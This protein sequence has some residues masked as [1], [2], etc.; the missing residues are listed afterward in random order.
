MKEIIVNV[1]N[2]NENSIKTIEGDNLS[3]VYKIYICKNKRRIDLT[4]KIAI[5]AYVNEYGNKKSNI[6]ALNITNASQ[7]EI[8][9]PITNVISNE[10][11]VYACQIAIYGE[12]N[13]LEQTAPFS[14]IVENNIFSKISNSAINSSDFHIL[15]EAIKTTNSYAKKLKE[16]TENIEL[17]YA[18]KLNEKL[19]KD[20]VLSMANMGQDVK[21]AMT[22][23]SVAVVGGNS[24]SI[25]NMDTL[26]KNIVGEYIDNKNSYEKFN[27]QKYTHGVGNSSEANCQYF[28]REVSSGEKIKFSSYVKSGIDVYVFT[29]EAQR[30]IS[31]KTADIDGEYND[32][33]LVP[34]GAKRVY[35]N[36]DWSKKNFEV[37]KLSTVKDINLKN[38]DKKISLNVEILKNDVKYVE[39]KTYSKEKVSIKTYNDIGEFHTT[40]SVYV[41]Y[42]TCIK[43]PDKIEGISAYVYSDNSGIATCEICDINFNILASA[44]EE[45]SAL[46]NKFTLFKFDLDVSKFENIW[47]RF[48]GDDTLKIRRNALETN[49][50]LADIDE[51]FCQK[52]VNPWNTTFDKSYSIPFDVITTVSHT[53]NA[54]HLPKWLVSLKGDGQTDDTKALQMALDYLNSIG[55]GK[56]KCPSGIYLLNGELQD[57]DTYNAIIKIPYNDAVSSPPISIEIEGEYG[58]ATAYPENTAVPPISLG[59]IF[60]VKRRHEVNGSFPSIIGSKFETNDNS[61]NNKTYT[62]ITLYLKNFIIRQRDDG[63]L[64]DMQLRYV[65]NVVIDNV[66]SDVDVDGKACSYPTDIRSRGLVLPTLN[67]YALVRVRNYYCIGRYTGMI[68]NEHTNIDNI[69]LQRCVRGIRAEQSHHGCYYGKILMQNVNNCLGASGD[70]RIYDGVLN[71]ENDGNIVII[72]DPNNA[73]Y[74][75]IKIHNVRVGKGAKNNYEDIVPFIKGAKNLKITTEEIPYLEISDIESTLNRLI[76]ILKLQKIIK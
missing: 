51:P 36:N 9:L 76:D 44:K 10:N 67:N 57:I 32:E 28:W 59:T 7:G 40:S 49:W 37:Y 4:N 66:V 53:L 47:V 29:D 13:S 31:V 63:N 70:C 25:E 48:Y 12:N 42:G 30:V 72:D 2:Y 27:Q 54:K 41:G 64:T 61:F 75:N 26:L 5:M 18:K 69:F 58:V 60:Y 73:L 23:G 15:S 24:V 1:D 21:E 33:L 62:D 55:G 52:G 6:L 3:E 17:Q 46:S 45:V 56:L 19:D 22:G 74:G 8:E 20:D 43:A 68:H 50:I 35:F 16:G 34:T 71:V 39:D 38:L 65:A 11:G 14:L